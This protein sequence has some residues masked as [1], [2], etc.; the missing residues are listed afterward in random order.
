[1]PTDHEN[2]NNGFA[3]YNLA[4]Q[5][6]LDRHFRTP[7]LVDGRPATNEEIA[8]MAPFFGVEPP[9]EEELKALMAHCVSS[10]DTD[11]TVAKIR[12][13]MS[14][15][16][17]D[18]PKMSPIII[19]SLFTEGGFKPGELMFFAGRNQMPMQSHKSALGVMMLAK[20]MREHPDQPIMITGMDCDRV[21]IEDMPSRLKEILLGIEERQ[22]LVLEPQPLRHNNRAWVDMNEAPRRK[23]K[24]ARAGRKHG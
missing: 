13:A 24:R 9:S 20:H 19:D 23:R 14:K 11:A 8:A 5:R 2:R 7:I 18:G 10:E 12:E 16:L 17:T 21:C 1:M 6:A 22:Q 4:D 15:A 3:S